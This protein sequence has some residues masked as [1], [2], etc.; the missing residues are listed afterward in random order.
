MQVGDELLET[1]LGRQRDSG[2]WCFRVRGPGV[3]EFCR[4]V[5]PDAKPRA[6]GW[7]YWG[8]YRSKGAAERHRTDFERRFMRKQH[9][10][11]LIKPGPLTSDATH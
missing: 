8:P 7:I 9:P 10:D 2:L 11:V 4:T 3:A 1:S 5:L 6:D